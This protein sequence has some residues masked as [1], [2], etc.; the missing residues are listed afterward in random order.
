MVLCLVP[1]MLKKKNYSYMVPMSWL[2]DEFLSFNNDISNS[3]TCAR[4]DWSIANIS[5]IFKNAQRV[6]YGTLYWNSFCN[7]FI[8]LHTGHQYNSLVFW[9]FLNDIGSFFIIKKM[10]F[11]YYIQYSPWS[12]NWLCS[13][14]RQSFAL[15]KPSCRQKRTSASISRNRWAKLDQQRK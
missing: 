9:I 3:V 13:S 10:K 6:W 7:L 15:L 8:W 5:I 2:L 4:V 12:Q 11:Y 1:F 14:N